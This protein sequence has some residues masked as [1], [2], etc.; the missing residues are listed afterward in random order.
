MDKD[1]MKNDEIIEESRNEHNDEA[2]QRR[3]FDNNE[4]VN[5]GDKG[6]L[7]L[8]RI[9]RLYVVLG[10][11]SAAVT[12]FVS[13]LFAIAGVTFGVLLNRQHKGSGNVIIISNIALALIN[14]A[15]SQV[16]LMLINNMMY[17]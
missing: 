7:A 10:W 16:I 3:L 5:S 2:Q 9:D 6:A 14:I 15:L 4:Q 11:I 13:P 12:I 1:F 17:R 8:E